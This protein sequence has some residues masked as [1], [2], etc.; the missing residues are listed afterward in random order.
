MLDV[1]GAG[2]T[3][4]SAQDWYD[5]WRCSPESN[6]VQKAIDGIHSEGRSRPAVERTLHTEFATS[7]LNQIIQLFKRDSLNHWRDPTYLM[8]KLIL[9][10]VGGLFIG[11]SPI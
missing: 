11:V 8:A 10:I 7:W 5:I 2:A 4:K 1:I 3:A 6:D 9:N